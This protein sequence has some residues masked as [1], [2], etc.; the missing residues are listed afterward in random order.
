MEIVDNREIFNTEFI[1]EI[2]ADKTNYLYKLLNFSSKYGQI[3]SVLHNNLKELEQ[4]IINDVLRNENVDEYEYGIDEGRKKGIEDILYS[5]DNYLSSIKPSEALD[6]FIKGDFKTLIADAKKYAKKIIMEIKEKIS[7]IKNNNDIEIK[8]YRV[9]GEDLKIIH[10]FFDNRGKYALLY[11]PLKTRFFDIDKNTPLDDIKTF[12]DELYMESKIISKFDKIPR[13][14]ISLRLEK[15]N[16]SQNILDMVVIHDNICETILINYSLLSIYSNNPE[17]LKISDNMLNSILLE[18]QSGLIDEDDITDA[19]D[20]GPVIFD[21]EELKYIHN[22]F[23][24]YLFDSS[25][26]KINKYN[27][28]KL[29][30]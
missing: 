18:V 3:E 30:K 1:K 9:Y 29:I 27:A 8:N 6:I 11:F 16:K 24:S 12:V 4:E 15:V 17:Q 23:V 26:K 14:Y 5:I 13:D 21:D 22:Y 10:D 7:L 25:D 20:N 2:N 28:L 19:I